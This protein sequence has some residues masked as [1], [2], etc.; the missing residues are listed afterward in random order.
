ME[1]K[2][3]KRLHKPAPDAEE[4]EADSGQ[5]EVT[6]VVTMAKD[7]PGQE[8]DSKEE[9]EDSP[10][11]EDSKEGTLTKVPPQRD[12]K[13][14]AKLKTGTKTTVTIATS[15]DT[16]QPN[17][18]RKIRASL[19]NLLRERSLKIILLPMEVQKNPN[20]PQPHSCPWPMKKP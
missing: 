3:T 15:E 6:L 17:A 5:E 19:R 9:E 11:K 2:P 8:E 4:E 20:W 16:L 1:G 18:P 10:A 14:L 13:Y 7:G 12:P